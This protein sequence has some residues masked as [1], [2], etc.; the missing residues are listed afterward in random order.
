VSAVVNAAT[1]FFGHGE[2]VGIFG[3]DLCQRVG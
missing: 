2:D 1:N 3:A